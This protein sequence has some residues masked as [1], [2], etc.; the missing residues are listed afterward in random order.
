MNLPYSQQG[1]KI[2]NSGINLILEIPR[3]KVVVTFGI[4]GFSVTLPFQYFGKNTQGHCGEN[5]HSNGHI[6]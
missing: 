2:M 4:T 3:L 1:V 5:V 6:S